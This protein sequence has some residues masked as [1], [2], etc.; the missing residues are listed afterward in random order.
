MV[1]NCIVFG[2][3]LERERLPIWRLWRCVGLES[4][5]RDESNAVA[6]AALL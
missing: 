5:M 3:A 2:V 6:V 1:D 4:R